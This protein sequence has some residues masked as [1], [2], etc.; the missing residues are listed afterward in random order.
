MSG[1]WRKRLRGKMGETARLKIFVGLVM[2]GMQGVLMIFDREVAISF[3]LGWAPVY[4][5][6]M[7][8][9]DKGAP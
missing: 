3:G 8:L 4:I 5:I 9:S 2:L 7:I 6:M 1:G